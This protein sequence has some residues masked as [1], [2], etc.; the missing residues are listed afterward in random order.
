MSS[1]TY[2]LTVPSCATTRV[3]SNCLISV[4]SKLR[5]VAT[6]MPFPVRAMLPL[7]VNSTPFLFKGQRSTYSHSHR[8]R[9]MVVY[10]PFPISRFSVSVSSSLH[11]TCTHP[12][13]DGN[14]IDSS[15]DNTCLRLLSTN[16]RTSRANRRKIEGYTRLI[17]AR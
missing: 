7:T 13:V 16:H 11:V 9:T 12:T 6:Q 8:P 15:Y 14:T 2:T 3:A 17:S 5:P 1:A 4:L 10:F